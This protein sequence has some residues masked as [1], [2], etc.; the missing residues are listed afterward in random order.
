MRDGDLLG[1]ECSFTRGAAVVRE[2][3][4]CLEGYQALWRVLRARQAVEIR[5]GNG[6]TS[7]VLPVGITW[8]TENHST[9]LV[10]N[11]WRDLHDR[12]QA[13]VGDRVPM[14]GYLVTGDPGVG[15]SGFLSYELYQAATSDRDVVF[16][17]VAFCRVW[18]FS[19]TGSV[20][21]VDGD[22]QTIVAARD[23]ETLFLF[24]PAGALSAR[25]PVRVNAFTLICASP[26][27]SRY[28][29]FLKHTQDSCVNPGVAYMPQPS[30]DELQEMRAA[31]FAAVPAAAVD[32]RFA[33]FGGVA[34]FAFANGETHAR[35]VAALNHAVSGCAAARVV[36][37]IRERQEQKDV[38][39]RLVRYVVA[40]DLRS[41]VS[42]EFA[43][44]A[45]ATMVCEKLDTEEGQAVRTLANSL[46]HIDGGAFGTVFEFF[47]HRMLAAGGTFPCAA[48]GG[49]PAL[50]Q[51]LV[52]R[53]TVRSMR[54]AADIDPDGSTALWRPS[55][56]N[57]PAFGGFMQLAAGAN[58]D[59]LQMKTR[60]GPHDI[61][62]DAFTRGCPNG[63]GNALR[64]FWVIP[65]GLEY[66]NFVL[67]TVNIPQ[68]RR[69][70]RQLV[71]RQYK[72]SIAL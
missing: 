59:G 69:R 7:V 27:R 52:P 19:R 40:A 38:S 65:E 49:A 66:D 8:L 48:L 16:E 30:L 68:P 14:N 61:S 29:N 70:E 12:I 13:A 17:S 24:D 20:T 31:A 45:I 44:R 57:Y 18:H 34:R 25:E 15:K 50:A 28:H 46:R 37:S 67:P 58:L 3:S 71:V 43:S 64:L 9:M 33:L 1:Y 53:L 54:T 2:P 26:N 35:N 23:V 63:V 60:R 56:S 39:H 72:L 6:I 21:E 5:H 4:G 41:V 47:A 62:R 42:V 36:K 11:C 10:R 32:E 51:L 55:V 22:V